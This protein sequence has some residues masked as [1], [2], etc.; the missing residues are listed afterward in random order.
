M[1]AP[2]FAKLAS[3]DLIRQQFDCSAREFA[4][5]LEIDI[6]AG[7]A[8]KIDFPASI[9]G[10]GDH[11][12]ATSHRFDI[13]Q[14]KPFLAAGHREN[15]S[16]GPER[17]YFALRQ[18][19]RELDIACCR[20]RARPGAQYAE[21]IAAAGDQQ[22]RIGYRGHDAGPAVDQFDMPLIHL[23]RVDS[24]QNQDGRRTAEIASPSGMS[25]SSVANQQTLALCADGKSSA[26]WRRVKLLFDSNR[27]A[28]STFRP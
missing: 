21:T 24:R 1:L 25:S 16:P 3:E 14:A 23:G 12:H 2:V 5:P 6:I 17:V 11:W 9:L 15:M 27:S 19:A 10:G 8:I 7:D 4:L 13:H 22:P 20:G 18:K 26:A 28:S